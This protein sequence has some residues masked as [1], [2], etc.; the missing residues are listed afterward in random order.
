MD[1]AL[2]Q[3]RL[4]VAALSV[5]SALCSMCVPARA[6]TSYERVDTQLPQASLPVAPEPSPHERHWGDTR[7]LGGHLFSRG[8]FV[9]TALID[10]Q[11]GVRAGV[12]Y[13]QVSGLAQ[14]PSLTEGSSVAEQTIRMRT[15]YAAETL[16]FQVRLHDYVAL[17]GDGYTKARVGA[18]TD[19]LLS[20]GADYAYG[21]DLGLAVKLLRIAGLQ[22]TVRG[23]LGFYAGQSAGILAFYQDLN[24]I[25][26]ET[27]Q[28]IVNQ[29]R[30][31]GASISEQQINTSIRR[32]NSQFREA[33]ADLVTPF[34]GFTFGFSLNAAFA[35]NRY[36]GMQGSV[37]FSHDSGT[38]KPKRYDTQTRSTIETRNDVE[39]WR[40]SF[41]LALDVDANPA[42]VPVAV[43]LEY[44][45]TPTSVRAKSNTAQESQRANTLEHLLALGLFY[46]GRSDLQL[47]INGYAIFSQAPAPNVNATQTDQPLNLAVQLVFRYYW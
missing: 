37:G 11:I 39:T 6:Q 8:S 41:G 18:N 27:T 42:K 3:L 4:G 17:F 10:S 16:D 45:A 33:T 44:V 43:M 24:T 31:Q 26:R 14:L 7:K 21:G 12:E 29:V 22:L 34:S 2:V 13:Q 1:R 47:G 46:S 35:V 32:L 15:L 25:A 19:T 38:Y 9:P 40:P 20:T 5:F 28:D 23:Q 30:A 36:L